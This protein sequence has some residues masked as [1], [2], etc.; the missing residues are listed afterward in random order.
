MKKLIPIMAVVAIAVVMVACNN[1]PV[2]ST[3][4]VLT[5]SDTTGLASFQQ[6]KAQNELAPSAS[7]MQGNEYAAR[8][9]IV[10]KYYTTR[11]V[12]PARRSY[13]SSTSRSSYSSYPAKQKRGW[14]KAAKGTVIGAGGGALIGALVDKHNRGMGAVIGG[15]LGGAGGYGIGRHMDKNDGRY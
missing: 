5:Y 11:I 7:Y 13:A 2:A 4:K 9:V 3:G 15:L 6:W 12:R 10:K 8:P 14:S 1:R